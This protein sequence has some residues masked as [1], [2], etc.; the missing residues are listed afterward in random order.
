[1]R[2]LGLIPARGGSKGVPRKNIRPLAGRP[3]LHYSIDAARAA[4]DVSRVIVSTE[5]EEI[6]QLSRSAGAEVPFLRPAGLASDHTPML[7]VVRHAIE[8]LESGGDSFDAVAILQPTSPIRRAGLIDECVRLLVE[9][10]ADSVITVVP[11]PDEFNPHWVYQVADEQ[12]FLKLSVGEGEPIARRQELPQAYHRD[13]SVYVVRR[14]VVIE[15]NSL[16]GRRIVGCILDRG[17]AVNI[18]TPEDWIAAEGLVA[19][20]SD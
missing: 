3:L 17:S 9:N 12:P 13:G 18:D 8:Q 10:H 7:P 4:A 14:D 5:D 20:S 15:L 6:A 19:R 16:Y 11:V 2:V 1:M